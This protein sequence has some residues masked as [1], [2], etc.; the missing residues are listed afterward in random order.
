[1]DQPS[2]SLASMSAYGRDPVTW[3]DYTRVPF[4]NV[5]DYNTWSS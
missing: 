4:Y 2:I 3:A 5:E 1:M